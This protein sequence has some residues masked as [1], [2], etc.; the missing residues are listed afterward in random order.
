MG[1]VWSKSVAH[2]KQIGSEDHTLRCSSVELPYQPK[3]TAP[4]VICSA[5]GLV[6]DRGLTRPTKCPKHRPGYKCTTPTYRPLNAIEISAFLQ[7]IVDEVPAGCQRP[8]MAEPLKYVSDSIVLSL[9][10]N[11]TVA[12][13]TKVQA[14]LTV[15]GSDWR[16][17]VTY[18][19]R[20]LGAS[21][22]PRWLS[23]PTLSGNLNQIP[24]P[25]QIPLILSSA[26]QTD[27]RTLNHTLRLRLRLQNQT[28]QDEQELS[29]NVTA[30]ISAVP[31]A[32]Q[33]TIDTDYRKTTLDEEATFAITARDLRQLSVER[34]QRYFGGDAD[35]VHRVLFDQVQ[36]VTTRQPCHK[37]TVVPYLT[38]FCFSDHEQI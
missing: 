25:V 28:A 37:G 14:S 12:D 38:Q 31:V 16:E 23:V 30:H 6:L 18:D 35:D 22:I 19:W 4:H 33:C 29:F 2:A 9:S 20:V 13:E 8:L 11:T 17:G 32:A 27:G 24:D 26:N 1:V 10:K 5:E 7:D 21:E 15:S 36:Q 3:P 34:L